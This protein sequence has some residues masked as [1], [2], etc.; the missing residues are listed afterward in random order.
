[1]DAIVLCGKCRILIKIPC[2]PYCIIC[3]Q[4]ME[5]I[6]IHDQQYALTL[7]MSRG[8]HHEYGDKNY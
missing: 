6:A 4:A 1:M 2:L 7:D 8:Y 3:C 5:K